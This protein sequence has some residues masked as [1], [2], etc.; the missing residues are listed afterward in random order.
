MLTSLSKAA[1]E[2]LEYAQPLLTDDIVEK[3]K[4]MQNFLLKVLKILEEGSDMTQA[5]RELDSMEAALWPEA[6]A[7]YKWRLLRAEALMRMDTTD[8]INQAVGI[9]EAISEDNDQ[10]AGYLSLHGHALI[11]ACHLDLGCDSLRK[12]TQVDPECTRTRNWLETGQK[13]EK[14]FNKGKNCLREGSFE[15]AKALYTEALQVDL[16]NWCLNVVMLNNRA[17]CEIK[18][19][20]YPAA[21]ADCDLALNLYPKLQLAND[22]KALAVSKMSTMAAMYAPPAMNGKISQGVDLR[23]QLRRSDENIFH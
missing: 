14:L 21:I 12:A 22:H 5:L 6:G 18:L 10:K 7:L 13:L 1:F 15:E 20:N 11:L 3:A 16:N 9:T 2:F 8:G 4:S 23:E 19:G 17:L